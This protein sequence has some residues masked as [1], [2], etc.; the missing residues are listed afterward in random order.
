MEQMRIDSMN[1][2]N[3]LLISSMIESYEQQIMNLKESLEALNPKAIMSR[4][5]SAITD[6]EGVFINSV[7]SLKPDDKVVIYMQDGSADCTVDNVRG[8]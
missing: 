5:Y 8:D 3:Q 6:S 1:N 2:E 7:S 4:G